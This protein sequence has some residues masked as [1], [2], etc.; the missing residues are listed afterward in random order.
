MH[1]QRLTIFSVAALALASSVSHA[2][3]YPPPIISQQPAPASFD[4]CDGWYLR[5]QVGIS[6]NNADYEL[7]T[8]PLPAGARYVSQSISDSYFAGVGVG[9]NFNSWLRFEGTVDYR[10]RTQFSALGRFPIPPGGQV[11]VDQ[12]D[13][14]MKSWVFLANAFVDLGTWNCFTPFVGAGIGMAWHQM[15]DWKDVTPLTPGGGSSAFGVGRDESKWSFAWALYAG[16][17]YNVTKSV[18]IDFTYR[19]MD[20]GS[21]K[22]IVDCGG[23]CGQVFTHNF[24]NLASHDF[25]LGIRWECCDLPAA[26]P[27]VV[28]APPPPLR[29]KG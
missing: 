12:L 28:Y 20:L 11:F 14:H 15:V 25:M 7:R 1:S 8:S 23:P 16:V 29:S 6:M 17:A 27:P 13:G 10:A 24:K 21:A 9:Y 22:E 18:K 2:A 26:P 3:D 19:Y 5:G 4:C